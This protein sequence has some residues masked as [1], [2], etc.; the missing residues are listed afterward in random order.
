[1]PGPASGT[2]F[3]DGAGEPVGNDQYGGQ[4][5][6]GGGR[7]VHRLRRGHRP[8]TTDDVEV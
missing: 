5:G 1:M 6:R 2:I 4:T 7:P 8:R 3:G